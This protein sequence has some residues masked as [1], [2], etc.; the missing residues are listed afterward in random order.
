[1]QPSL[2]FNFI[3]VSV[4]AA[5]RAVRMLYFVAYIFF[6]HCT[7][8]FMD[9]NFETWMP[10]SQLQEGECIEAVLNGGSGMREW[11]TE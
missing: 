4:M 8:S 3:L 5:H 7:I 2:L 10:P 9:V 6:S 1:M 11:I